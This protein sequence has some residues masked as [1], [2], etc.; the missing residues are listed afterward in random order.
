MTIDIIEEVENASLG[1]PLKGL[2][3]ENGIHIFETKQEILDQQ[4]LSLGRVKNAV[5]FARDVKKFLIFDETGENYE[6]KDIPSGQNMD[7]YAKIGD[8]V[9]FQTIKSNYG[10]DPLKHSLE[11]EQDSNRWGKMVFTNNLVL[12]QWD[13]PNDVTNTE[14]TRFLTIA[15]SGFDFQRSPK[16]LGVKLATIE[17]LLKVDVDGALEDVKT[18]SVGEGLSIDYDEASK[19]LKLKGDGSHHE[20][21]SKTLFDNAVADTNSTG[22]GALYQFT[23]AGSSFS[24]HR[25][26]FN[27]DGVVWVLNLQDSL[28]SKFVNLSSSVGSVQA[29]SCEVPVNMVARFTYSKAANAINIEMSYFRGDLAKYE[30]ESYITEKIEENN[31]EIITPNQGAQ[32]Q[33]IDADKSSGYGDSGSITYYGVNYST[34]QAGV[35]IN[36]LANSKSYFVHKETSSQYGFAMLHESYVSQIYNQ[37]VTGVSELTMLF[38][39]ESRGRYAKSNQVTPAG[40]VLNWNGEYLPDTED[41]NAINPTNWI[42]LDGN[43]TQEWS[44]TGIKTACYST[45]LMVND[46]SALLQR[47]D[48]FCHDNAGVKTS[49]F[50]ADSASEFFVIPIKTGGGTLSDLKLLPLFMSRFYKLQNEWDSYTFDNS[51]DCVGTI[52]KIAYDA[53]IEQEEEAIQNEEEQLLAGLAGGRLYINKL[54]VGKL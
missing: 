8:D 47:G 44:N 43:V 28:R 19:D 31:D 3:L 20:F 27:D 7:D 45:G 6:E 13:N 1:R 25:H 22:E 21:K 53:A 23:G 54:K 42:D 50:T 49:T 4:A 10:N 40:M 48:V 11:L 38:G 33:L 36:E 17:E 32:F 12:W 16:Y 29:T 37:D 2:I 5:I 34:G 35:L 52:L 9:Q 24:T 14:K 39:P 15:Q 30:A 26:E 41:A 46:G 18:V 51:A